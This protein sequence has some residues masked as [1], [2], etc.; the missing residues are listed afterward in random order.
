LVLAELK[1]HSA[2]TE[3]EMPPGMT[4]LRNR[5]VT[6]NKTRLMF[7][8]TLF[9]LAF[10]AVGVVLYIHSA[11]LGYQIVSIKNDI[12]KLE[13]QNRRLEYDIAQLASLDRVQMEAERKLGM[14]RPQPQ[15][16]VA[17]VCDTPQITTSIPVGS[18]SQAQ[19]QS[20]SLKQDYRV[21]SSI[22]N[23]MGLDGSLD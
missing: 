1:H 13:N 16:M 21:V 8:I 19:P 10:C 11:L 15:N 9:V 3:P 14:F 6:F 5:T 17:L 7:N 12:A 2:F 22:L 20:A 23:R 4:R 18:G